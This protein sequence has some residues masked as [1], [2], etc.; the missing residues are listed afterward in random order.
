[1]PL[2][3]SEQVPFRA[4]PGLMTM[5]RACAEQ[6]GRS[7]AE[8]LRLAATMYVLTR[9]LADLQRPETQALYGPRLGA[10]RDQVLRDLAAVTARATGDPSGATAI[11]DRLDAARDA[12]LN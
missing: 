9:A 8:E 5:I 10:Y 1:M 2:E 6:S 11:T 4:D 3:H 12:D 7:V